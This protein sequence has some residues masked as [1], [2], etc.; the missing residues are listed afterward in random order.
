MKLDLAKLIIIG[1]I[2][3]V[4]SNLYAWEKVSVPEYVNKKTKSPWNFYDNFE[5]QK[6]G[7]MNFR[8]YSIN[9][10]GEGKKPFIIKQDPNGNKF[11]EITVKHGWN[12]CCGTWVKTERAEI[13]A[14]ES[15]RALN[16]EIL[17]IK[18]PPMKNPI[19]DPKR[20]IVFTRAPISVFEKPKSK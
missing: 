18:K 1:A 6:L 15:S 17:F 5:D 10:K 14:G 3:T 8:R 20:A 7:K 9:D 4:A 2:V 12:K 16:K 13:E 11:L 19:T